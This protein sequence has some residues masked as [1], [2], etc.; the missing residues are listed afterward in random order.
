MRIGLYQAFLSVAFATLAH[1]SEV[2]GQKV[3]E[4]KVTLQINNADI[5][6]VLD[7]IENVTKVKF[8]YN[9]QIFGAEHKLNYKFQNESL[10]DVLNK[11]S[12]SVSGCLRGFSGTYHFK[13]P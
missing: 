1:A 7:K 10:A 9:P 4:Q 12:F 2:S 11:V 6:R 13:T 8:M 5:E 3:L